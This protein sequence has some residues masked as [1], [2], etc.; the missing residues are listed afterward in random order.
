M[1]Y[2]EDNNKIVLFDE[3]KQRLQNTIAFMPQY[4][5][6]EIKE[7]QKGYV[8]YD[9]KLMTVEEMNEQLLLEAKNK[10]Y[11]ENQ[12][13]LDNTRS[14]HVFTVE[15]QG[16]QCDFDTTSKTQADLN[17]AA[18]SASMGQPW[19]W[20]TNNRISL[21]L[22]AEDIQTISATYMTVVNN[23]IK[24]WTY[25][26]ELIENATTLEEVE[27][28][29][30][31]YTI[32]WVTLTINNTPK[33][34]KVTINDEVTK[35][36]TL[37]TYQGEAAKFDYKVEA[38]DYIAKE[39]S[40]EL[41]ESKELSVALDKLLTDVT[42]TINATPNDAKVTINGE[43]RTTHTVQHWKKELVTFNYSVE[44]EGYK[45]VTGTEEISAS[46]EL[47]VV[48]EAEEAEATPT[49]D[50]VDTNE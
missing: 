27:A 12:K 31:D 1:F 8:V 29:R 34:A 17:S 37:I 30:I 3:D 36:A 11:E 14:S 25:F 40:I 16:Q 26:D 44:A 18:I 24:K 20:T 6:L 50:N 35:E 43:E 21:M 9:F 5:C 47:D 33:S 38:N 23:D 15:I 32:A 41:V 48:L 28:I 2:I 19:L 42:F 49:E 10:K 7:V 4:E 22:T 45:A 39:D 13:A 46:K